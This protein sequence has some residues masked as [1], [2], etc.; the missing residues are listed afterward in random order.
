MGFG[1]RF[2]RWTS[3][4]LALFQLAF[5]VAII[6]LEVGS[7]IIDLA[8]GTIWVGYWAGIVF[9]NTILMML[10]ISELNFLFFLCLNIYFS[11]LFSS[12][13]LPWSLLCNLCSFLE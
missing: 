5:T 13:L 8:H 4:V 6:G 1:E 2:P 3:G 9:L 10:F 7:S 12:L 11:I